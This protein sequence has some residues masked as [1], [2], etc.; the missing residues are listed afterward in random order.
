MEQLVQM[1]RVQSERASLAQQTAAQLEQ[2]AA[3]LQ[4]QTVGEQS[5][6]EQQHPQTVE[7]LT[8]AMQPHSD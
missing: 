2:Q 5:A 1:Q 6:I 4:T 7:H 8:V 3:T